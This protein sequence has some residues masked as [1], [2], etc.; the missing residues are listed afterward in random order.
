MAQR[1]AAVRPEFQEW[2]PCVEPGRWYPAAT[3][4]ET[5]MGQLASGEPRWNNEGR[6]PCDE[7]FHFRGGDG[8]RTA[9]A[10]TRHTD[11]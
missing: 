6:V 1:E 3:L 7:H 11:G 8:P 4:R 2:Y 10:R 5:V 9:P